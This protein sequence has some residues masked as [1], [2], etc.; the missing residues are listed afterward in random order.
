MSK[1]H[2]HW[3][4]FI[5]LALA[6]ISLLFFLYLLRP[7]LE[8]GQSTV[9]PTP[10]PPSETIEDAYY[11]ETCNVIITLSSKRIV[12]ISTDHKK[13]Q[14]DLKCYQIKPVTISPDKKYVA[15]EGSDLHTKDKTGY[16]PG[17]SL[18][19]YFASKKSYAHISIGAAHVLRINISPDD[20]L[21]SEMEYEKEHPV[22]YERLSLPIIE[23]HF[24]NTVDPQTKEIILLDGVIVK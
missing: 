21:S 16:A 22:K 23:N 15:F 12:T 13:A 8:P 2:I 19:I 1:L 5:L 9:T 10:T 4:T 6:S 18:T 3:H 14:P 7:G 20:I 17:N 24:E 11:D